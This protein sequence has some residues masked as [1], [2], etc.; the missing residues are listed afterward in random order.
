MGPTSLPSELS[1]F[2]IPKHTLWALKY[3][4]STVPPNNEMILENKAYE[5]PSS[6]IKL[7]TPKTSSVH[8]QKDNHL[9]KGEFS[10]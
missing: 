8:T 6:I 10:K 2:I 3:I 5:L 7:M 4:V 1:E 9:C